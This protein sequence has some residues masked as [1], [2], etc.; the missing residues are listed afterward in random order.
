[1]TFCSAHRLLPELQT[2]SHLVQLSLLPTL[3]GEWQ[4]CSPGL[5]YCVRDAAM[6]TCFHS[7]VS[8]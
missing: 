8:C 1:M 6:C 2:T 4:G 3:P 5:P 7:L